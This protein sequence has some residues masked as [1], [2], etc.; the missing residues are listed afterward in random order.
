MTGKHCSGLGLPHGGLI[1]SILQREFKRRTH[2]KDLPV[3]R[4]MEMQVGETRTMKQKTN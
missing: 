1:V 4:D 2:S 3:V